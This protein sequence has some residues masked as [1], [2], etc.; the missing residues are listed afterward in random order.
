[1]N[2]LDM[3]SEFEKQIEAEFELLALH[4][5]PYHFGSG[6]VAYKIK[7]K[8]IVI[9][10]DGKE[11]IIELSASNRHEDYHSASLLNIYQGGIETFFSEGIKRLEEN[12][13]D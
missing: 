11:S 10:F 4:Y 3:V 5:V 7:G 8:N 13:A 1:M 2:F 6:K 9:S 12:I